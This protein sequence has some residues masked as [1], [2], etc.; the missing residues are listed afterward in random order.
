MNIGDVKVG[1]TIIEP[2][3]G[4]TE[5][6]KVEHSPGSCR[7]KVHING[8]QCYEGFANVMVRTK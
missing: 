8:R 7:G 1:D 4:K 6:T 2:G 3:G 5:V